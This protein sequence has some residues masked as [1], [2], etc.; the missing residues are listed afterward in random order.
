MK[1]CW[2][3]SKSD[4]NGIIQYA[5][6][7]QE[8]LLFPLLMC[9][10]VA[11]LLR[12]KHCSSCLLLS[13]ASSRVFY[14]S[15]ITLVRCRV[16]TAQTFAARPVNC[17][18]PVLALHQLKAM[19]TVEINHKSMLIRS[20]Q[21]AFFMRWMPEMP[22]GSSLMYICLFV[23]FCPVP[24]FPLLRLVPLPIIHALQPAELS[25]SGG[26]EEKWK[27]AMRGNRDLAE[28]CV[29]AYLSKNP[30]QNYPH[31]EQNRIS[32]KQPWETRHKLWDHIDQ[33]HDGGDDAYCYCV[34]L[35]FCVSKIQHQSLTLSS[36]HTPGGRMDG[37]E[38]RKKELYG[39]EQEGHTHFGSLYFPTFLAAFKSVP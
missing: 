1:E 39:K 18:L 8:R 19:Y 5:T 17:V 34:A 15:S 32:H 28:E 29:I 6:P 31:Q 7:A 26:K 37:E 21:T 36:I 35:W 4:C 2:C 14:F 30:K 13:K 12:P 10:I 16:F 27:I 38:G 24:L 20:I 23:S 11:S 3:G 9:I 25:R 33:R 22:S